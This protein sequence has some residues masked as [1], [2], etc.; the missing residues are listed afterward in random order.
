MFTGNVQHDLAKRCAVV[1]QLEV[2]LQ[3]GNVADVSR[4]VVA[5]RRFA[6]GDAFLALNALHRFAGVGI[7]AVVDDCFRGELCKLVERLDDVFYR[8]EVVQMICV[9]VQQHSDVRIQF[10][11]RIHKLAR[12]A[13]H[14]VAGT[15]SAA[16]VNTGQLAADECG[17]VHAGSEQ[18]LCHHRSRGRLAVCAGNADGVVI[19]AGHDAQQF[20]ALQHRYTACLGSDQFRVVCHDGCSVDDQISALDIL[21]TLSQ[22]YRDA[23]V[24][25]SLERFCFVVVR[26]GEVIALGVQYLCQRIH[27]AAAD[28]DEVDVLFSL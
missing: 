24:P 26:A 7:A 20:A 15:A 10:Q 19:P 22:I 12:L 16:A 2:G 25:D 8:A 6:E 4:V 21:R 13:G 14:D 9:N 18:D 1:H 17:Q 27:T 11:E 5:F 3:T 23:H 28:A